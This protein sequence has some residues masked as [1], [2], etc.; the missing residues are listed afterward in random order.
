MV[1]VA[2]L[3]PSSHGEFASDCKDSECDSEDVM[4]VALP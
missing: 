4:G 2:M 1:I 3:P